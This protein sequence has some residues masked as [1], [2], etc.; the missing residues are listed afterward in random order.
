MD[1]QEAEARQLAHAGWE[2]FLAEALPLEKRYPDDAALRF[3]VGFALLM[4]NRPAE[5]IER[6][7]VAIKQDYMK[8]KS[9]YNI[10]CAHAALGDS[11]AAIKILS[12]LSVAGGPSAEEMEADYDLRSLREDPRFVQLVSKRSQGMLDRVQWMGADLTAAIRDMTIDHD[13]YLI[14]TQTGEVTCAD[15]NTAD[16]KYL[17]ALNTGG[18]ELFTLSYDLHMEG[19]YAESLAGFTKCFDNNTNRTLS[20]YNIACANARLGNSEEALTWLEKSLKLGALGMT[21]PTDDDDFDSISKSV[22]FKELIKNA[23]A[24][25]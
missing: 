4:L 7:E 2:A 8:D 11:D 10:A 6:F 16:A 20:A 21:D 13:A 19:K 3:R 5:A 9:Q 1:A 14:N 15:T 22:K 24:T 12:E 17:E 25:K 23:E 18:G